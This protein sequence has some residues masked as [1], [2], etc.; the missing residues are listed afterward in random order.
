M[1]NVNDGGVQAIT[2]DAN[3]GVNWWGEGWTLF[4]KN[5][6][7]WVVFALILLIAGVVLSFIPFLGSLAVSLLTPVVV[8]SCLLAARKTEQGG[9]LDIN[10]LGLA[11]KSHL[12]P[13]LILG[14]LFLAA[15]VIIMVVMGVLGFG[16]VMG[17]GAGGAAHSMGGMMAAFGVGM[18]A[19]LV[20]A[21]LYVPV[22][23]AMWFAPALVVFR[24]VPP[25]N[26]LQAS[27]AACLRNIVPFLLYGIIFFVVAIVASIPMGLGWLV[28][29]PLTILTTYLAYRDIFND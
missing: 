24:D 2:V 26:A 18:L 8:G 15:N 23:M 25:V 16:A 1:V 11:F 13:L 14:A 29:I 5:A 21:A 12:N 4:T 28:L 17:M 22:S 3:R 7:L 20:G 9:T 6:G 10:D 27:F 19:L